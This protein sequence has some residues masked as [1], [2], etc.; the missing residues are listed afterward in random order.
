MPI[1]R[2][3]EA[4]G[5]TAAAVGPSYRLEVVHGDR[6]VLLSRADLEEMPQASEVLPIACVEG[7][8]ASGTWTGVR[9]QDLLALVGAPAHSTVHL[10]LAADALRRSA[11]RPCP[12]SSRPT[13]AR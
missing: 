1:N 7:W 11:R 2:S 5:V 13:R 4:A 9:L 12:P 10:T 8:S 6:T 3:A